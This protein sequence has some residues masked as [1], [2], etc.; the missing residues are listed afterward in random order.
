MDDLYPYV[1]YW[2][3]EVQGVWFSDTQRLLVD[4]VSVP[5]ISCFMFYIH[6]HL[7]TFVNSTISADTM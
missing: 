5:A 7:M 6:I 1:G 2:A 3:G 4:W